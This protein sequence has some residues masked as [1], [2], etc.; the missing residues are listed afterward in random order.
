MIEALSTTSASLQK[1]ANFAGFPV[2]HHTLIGSTNDRALEL[3]RAGQDQV[4]VVADQQ[5]GGRGRSGRLWVSPLGNLYASLS[6]VDPCAMAQSPQL[7]FVAGLAIHDAVQSLTSCGPR[8]RIKWPNDL[9][10]DGAKLSGL[11]LEGGSMGHHFVMTIGIGLNL[12][13]H[14]ADTPYH[15]TDLGAAGFSVTRDACLVALHHCMRN[16]MAAWDR[17][18]GFAQIR[19]AWLQRAAFLDE[20]ITIRRGDKPLQG[21]FKT[22]DSDG[23]LVLGT[24]DGDV[25]IDAGD[26]YPLHHAFG[27]QQG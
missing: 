8:L 21:L 25:L 23:R 12:V 1:P 18:L 16:W 5:Q 20:M 17:G 6:L 26:L 3:A 13:T 27:S 4:W 7:G 9:L 24:Q 15:A 2:E 19:E 10:L 14:P 22:L 11:L